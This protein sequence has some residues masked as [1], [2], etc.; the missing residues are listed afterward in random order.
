LFIVLN[1][2]LAIINETEMNQVMNWTWFLCQLTNQPQVRDA[3]CFFLK[4]STITIIQSQ[5]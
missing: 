5:W 1:K 4:K 2:I 3:L